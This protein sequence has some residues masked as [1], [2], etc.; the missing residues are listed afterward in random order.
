M[1][2]RLRILL[3]DDEPDMIKLVGKRLESEGYAVI[4]AMDGQEALGKAKEECPDLILLD[5]M[6]PKLNGFEVCTL[7][8]QDTRY[9][10]IPIV[11][12]TA[13]AQAKDEQMGL[14]CGANAYVRKPFKAAELLGAVKP[15][16]RKFASHD[17]GVTCSKMRPRHWPH[18]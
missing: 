1:M 11:M 4:V 17:A 7:L 9:Q 13:K 14:S 8:K 18:A 12:F 15:P 2:E 16:Q 6:L 10:N 5:L 3:V